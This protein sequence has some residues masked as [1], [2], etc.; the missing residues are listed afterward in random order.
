M[1]EVFKCS[2]QVEREVRSGEPHARVLEERASE[3]RSSSF[4]GVIK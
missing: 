2:C 1:E 3:E 4:K